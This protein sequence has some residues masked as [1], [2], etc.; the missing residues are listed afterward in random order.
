MK[1]LARAR[2][3]PSMVVAFVALLVAMGGTGYAAIVLPANSVG[4]KQLKKGAV[5]GKKIAKNAVNSRKVKNRSLLAVDFKSGQ[6]PAGPQGPQGP[7]GQQGP[8]GE[9]GPSNAFQAAAA[10]PINVG[11][12]ST[13]LLTL[14][15]PSAG[16]YVVSSKVY[17][18]NNNAAD[19]F[20]QCNLT[21]GASS[22]IGSTGVDDDGGEDDHRTLPGLLA[23]TTAGPATATLACRHIAG[24]TTTA[25][26]MRIV[27]IQVG[28]LTG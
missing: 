17:F 14:N 19:T 6:L 23:V 16:S 4:A 11:A 10:G 24:G 5:K 7:Q 20:V 27:A 25:N 1:Y 2:P 22:D 18:N 13:E 15:L 3:S 8:Q 12:T 9:R 26:D 28:S 21:V